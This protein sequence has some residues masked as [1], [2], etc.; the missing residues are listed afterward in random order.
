MSPVL[1]KG[2]HLEVQPGGFPALH[3]H[4]YSASGDASSDGSGQ[5]RV[6]LTIPLRAAVAI[7]DQVLLQAPKSLF[8]LIDDDQGIMEL[9]APM[10]G[11]VGA[12]LMEVLPSP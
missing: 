12:K 11:R 3:G 8:R 4:L 2:D 10:I 6:Y 1:Y 5:T 7:G 9:S